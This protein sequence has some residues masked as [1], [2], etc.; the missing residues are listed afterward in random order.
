MPRPHATLAVSYRDRIGAVADHVPF[1]E[2][3]AMIR[4]LRRLILRSRPIRA[5]DMAMTED[6]SNTTDI[7]VSLDTQRITLNRDDLTTRRNAL[8]TFA[9]TLTA[10]HETEPLPQAPLVTAIDTDLDSFVALMRGIAPFA[11]ADTGTADIF[12]ERRRL[13]GQMLETLRAMT[14]R[15]QEKLDE[16][17]EAIADYNANLGGEDDD[18]RFRALLSA[19]RLIATD[20]TTALPALPDT[21]RDTL[22][23]ASR[24]AFVAQRDTLLSIADSATTLGGLHDNLAAQTATNASFHPEPL[25]LSV[26]AG[27]LVALSDTM[28]RRATALV[29]SLDERLALVQTQ[30]D[31]H[32]ASSDTLERIELLSKAAEILFGDDFK[33]IPDFGLPEAQGAEWRSAWGPGATPSG[34]LLDYQVNT[35]G[36]PY[37]VDDWFTGMARV[38]GKMRDLETTT[39]LAD[40]FGTSEPSLSPLQ[41][42][43]RENVPWLALEFPDTL[44]DATPLVIDEDKLLY[45]AHF[46][47]P[48]SETARQAGLLID[49]WTE[50]VPSRTEDTGL[51]FHYD[52]PNSE[53]P[54]SLL[55]ALPADFTGSWQWADL[56]DS[57]RETMDL[58][59]RRAIEPDQMDTT[60]YARFLPAVISAV[61]LFPLTASLNFSF[62]NNLAAVLAE[63]QGD[64]DG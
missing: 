59:K 30:L 49:E 32:A 50:V 22:N 4:A 54:Q 40:A 26:S 28:A 21:F 12:S 63:T 52:R 31:A 35:L 3:A 29:A 53:P 48:F 56:V 10:L 18:V 47:V 55:L 39:R 46:A 58:A 17:D 38:R 15:W 23:G 14:D 2:L 51:A 64:S 13:F 8:A 19:E 62:N 1:F 42:P 41:F 9:S 43:Q 34:A 37:P 7:D 61:T 33:L 5:T 57:V 16:F 45:T 36:R 20:N 60:A 25:D 44:P 24:A 11:E 6:A 27:E